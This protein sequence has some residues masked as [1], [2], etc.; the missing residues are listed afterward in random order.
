MST[1][2]DA[3][4][5]KGLIGDWIEAVNQN[6]P[7]RIFGLVSDDLEMI[8]P[9]EQPVT[10]PQAHRLLRGFFEQF[11]LGLIGTT[12]ELVVSGDWAFR[13]YVYQLTLTPKAGG[14]ANTLKGQGVHMFRRQHDGSWKFA[15][16]IWN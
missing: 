10:G 15:K 13:R 2:S 12:L 14:D 16:D 7:D 9:G 6:D 11:T 3:E 4:V 1:Q 5:V 8:P